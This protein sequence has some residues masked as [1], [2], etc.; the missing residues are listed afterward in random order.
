MAA[1]ALGQPRQGV[2]LQGEA[3][4]LLK[5]PIAHYGDAA[6]ARRGSRTSRD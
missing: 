5:L 3:A 4:A 1:A 6:G 2:F